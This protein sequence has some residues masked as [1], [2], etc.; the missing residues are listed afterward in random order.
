[1]PRWSVVPV[2]LSLLLF[3]AACKSGSS[4]A[5]GGASANAVK[6]G[7]ALSLTGAAAVYGSQQRAGI[8]TAVE[9]VNASNSPGGVSLEVLFEDDGST[10]E[11]GINVFQKFI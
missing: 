8:V 10:K 7:A 1:M 4:G 2:G 11:Q 9:T 3:I 5:D 6:I